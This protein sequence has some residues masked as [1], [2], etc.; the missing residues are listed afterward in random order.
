LMANGN[1]N[2]VIASQLNVSL[3]TVRNHVQSILYKLHVHSKLEAVAVATREGII[4][5]PQR[6]L[7][8]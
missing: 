2:R 7:L 3:N 6:S 4:A 1:T 5:P 8:N